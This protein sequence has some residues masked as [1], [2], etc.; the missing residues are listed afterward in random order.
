M[1]ENSAPKETK[2][3]DDESDSD[4]SIAADQAST[5]T[6]SNSDWYEYPESSEEDEDRSFVSVDPYNP[7]HKYII[8]PKSSPS[9]F[10]R[11]F[12]DTDYAINDPDL[13]LWYE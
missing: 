6:E 10:S 11:S 2:T 1:K 9:R 5:Y 8:E 12:S 4:N 3:S 7:D 13:A